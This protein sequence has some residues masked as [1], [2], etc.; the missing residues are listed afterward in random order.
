MV[1]RQ[2]SSFSDSEEAYTRPLR[3]GALRGDEPSPP[4][5]GPRWLGRRVL[6]ADEPA[7]LIATS[8]P[9]SCL[10]GCRLLLRVVGRNADPIRSASSPSCALIRPWGAEV[11]MNKSFTSVAERY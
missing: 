2:I 1:S 7:L 6:D 11:W 10:P 4:R 9:K 5:S 3:L 8:A